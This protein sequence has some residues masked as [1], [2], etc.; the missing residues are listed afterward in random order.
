MLDLSRKRIVDF[1]KRLADAIPCTPSD[2][3]T[4]RE[5]EE[6]HLSKL[7]IFYLNY[8]GRGIAARP[9]EVFF[10]QEFWN[11]PIARSHGGAILALAG[12]IRK[13]ADLSTYLSRDASRHGYCGDRSRRVWEPEKDLIL[14]GFCLHH[15]HLE[16]KGRGNELVFVS[17]DRTSAV[18]A[19]AGNHKSFMDGSV[20]EAHARL[21]FF[22]GHTVSGVAPS[23]KPFDT[24]QQMVLAR[25]GLASLGQYDGKVTA[26]VMIMSSGHSFRHTRYAD[27]IMKI[28]AEQEPKL[29]DPAHIELLF[30]NAPD[31]LGSQ[32][33]FEW[34][35]D[36]TDLVL[37]ER[38][39]ATSFTMWQGFS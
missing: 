36:N 33:A 20:A 23:P 27:H 7:L 31:R 12:E 35:M 15:L 16:K 13:G 24:K 30:A 19:C 39:S 4:R 1:H 18:F 28:L 26:G 21:S 22:A 6:N 10:E 38:E 37:L 34:H 11:H 8:A 25:S 2:A 9:R 14:N 32:C 17:F 5:L 3:K 29:D